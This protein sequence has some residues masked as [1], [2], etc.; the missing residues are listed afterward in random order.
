MG[1]VLPQIFA[2]KNRKLS[3]KGGKIH[4]FGI[5]VVYNYFD[6]LHTKDCEASVDKIMTFFPL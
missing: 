2:T 6:V 1:K 5:G 4:H 3:Q